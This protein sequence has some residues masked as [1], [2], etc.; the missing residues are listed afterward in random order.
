MGISA[1]Y[2]G[3]YVAVVYSGAIV[4]SLAAGPTVARFGAI[5]VSQARV[6]PGG[7]GFFQP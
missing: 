3:I 7:G 5:R 4:A 6:Q 2:I 1:V